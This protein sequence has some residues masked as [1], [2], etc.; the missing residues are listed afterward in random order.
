MG[1]HAASCGK[2]AFCSVHTFDVFGRGFQSDE[3]D[4]FAV[5][6]SFYRFFSAESYLSASR[7]GGS[8]ETAGDL[9]Y[10]LKSSGIES[11]V[12]QRVELFGLYLEKRFLLGYHAFVDEIASDLDSRSRG[13]L[14]VSGLE[15]IELAL[16]DGELHILH[17]LVFLFETVCYL[18]E[19][20]VN[21]SVGLFELIDLHRGTDTCDDVFALSVHKIF[22]VQSLFAGG[23]VTGERNACTGSVAHVAE[24]HRLDVDCGAPAAGDIVHTTVDDSARVVPAAENGFDRFDELNLRILR[25]IVSLVFFVESLEFSDELLQVFCGELCILSD[26]PLV[27]EL[28]DYLFERTLR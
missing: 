16:F 2:N 3:D 12:Q 19:F 9:F 21:L 5:L 26:A 24:Y 17:I 14:A 4:L 1:G 20:I 11:R 25:E 8:R 6:S 23:R 10:L 27:F 15:H 22:A 28:V 13:S 18:Y 7:A